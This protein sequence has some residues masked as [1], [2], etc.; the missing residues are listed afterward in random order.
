VSSKKKVVLCLLAVLIFTSLTIANQPLSY[1]ISIPLTEG[2]VASG[3]V[4]YTGATD[5]V[6]LGSYN[7]TGNQIYG[8]VW[9]HNH[10]ATNL[11]FA[12]DGTYYSLYF[13]NATHL[14][15]FTFTGGFMTDSY[16][17][18]SVAGLYTT[19]YMAGGDGQNNHEYYT[20][21][22]INEVNQDNCEHHK[23]M[24]AGSDIVT[25]TGNCFIY[26][27]VGDNVSLRTADVGD[28]GTGN[29]YS[30]NLNLVRIGD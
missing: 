9:Y 19:T 3:Y 15:G 8:G 7:I 1:D 29:Y 4:P 27:D 10:T 21:I 24:S 12:V 16:L 26:L 11:N 20:S 28:T 23:K 6:D 25:H 17:T 30:S 13:T 18:A 22:F 5:N 2:D 14:N